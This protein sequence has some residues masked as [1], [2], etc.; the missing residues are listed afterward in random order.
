MHGLKFIWSRETPTEVISH[1]WNWKLNRNA[2]YL[3]INVSPSGWSGN[4]FLKKSINF[5]QIHLISFDCTQSLFPPCLHLIVM[6][7]WNKS[8]AC[9][10]VQNSTACNLCIFM[11][12]YVLSVGVDYMYICG[13]M[14][15]INALHFIC[16]FFFISLPF[17][18]WAL[19]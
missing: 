15:L 13:K 5:L 2:C 14:F 8:A 1:I 6:D 9:S 19:C 7:R 11:C 10:Y 18:I 4:Y 3:R 12:A 17:S 16:I